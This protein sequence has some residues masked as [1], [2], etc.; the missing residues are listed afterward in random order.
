MPSHTI[1]DQL[2]EYESVGTRDLAGRRPGHVI[3]P[4]GLKSAIVAAAEHSPME[5]ELDWW[6]SESKVDTL[7]DGA[8][9][10]AEAAGLGDCTFLLDPH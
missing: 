6:I 3:C 5:P 8:G 7:R 2:Q 1:A 9:E 4:S 10:L